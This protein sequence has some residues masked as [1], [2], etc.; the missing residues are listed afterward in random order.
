MVPS[1]SFSSISPQS[2]TTTTSTLLFAKSNKKKTKKA[3]GNNNKSGGGGGTKSSGFEWAK[4]F[5][6][7]PYEGKAYREIASLACASFEGRTG[8][9]LSPNVK[10]VADIPKALWKAPNVACLVVDKYN[11]Q[12]IGHNGDTNMIIKYANEVAL[13][14]LGLKPDEFESI[15]GYMDPDTNEWCQ[16]KS[17][18]A[19]VL[20]FL[21]LPFEMKGTKKYESGYMKKMIKSPERDVTIQNAHRWLLEKGGI[22]DG[23]FVSQTIGVAYAWDTWI[24]DIKNEGDNDGESKT[25]PTPTT[26]TTSYVCHGGGIRKEQ[27]DI[28]ELKEKISTQGNYIRQLKEQQGMGN[29]DSQVIDAVQILLKLKSQL[30]DEIE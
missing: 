24:L 9:P 5:T 15:L 18:F 26:T 14:T 12:G 2:S 13:E 6:I 19:P 21:D 28:E 7:T 1:S 16:P 3:G 29:Q 25:T 4:S 10:V 17:P 27:I 23:K 11:E 20:S 8:S 30:K 22:V